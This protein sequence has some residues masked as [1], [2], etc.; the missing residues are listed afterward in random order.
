M[1]PI[2]TTHAGEYLV[3]SYI[4]QNLKDANGDRVNVWVPSKDTGIDLLVTDKA[5][6][7]TTSVQV[8]FSKDFLA[9]D[10]NKQ[11]YKHKL[12]ACGWWKL[13]REQVRKSEADYWV[14]VL[15]A[16][17][18][19]TV[20]YVIITPQELVQRLDVIHPDGAM[21]HLYLWVSK[22]GRC[23]ETRTLSRE[24]VNALVSEDGHVPCEAMDLSAF[25]NAWPVLVQSW[26]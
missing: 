11:I 19:K 26:R 6:Q 15:P 3:G 2:F 10:R 7:C 20:Q 25:L 5:N 12:K 17:E 4:E 16:F 13:N 22:D 9:T 18:E 21:V 8:K 24:Q 1:Q 14:F 23:W